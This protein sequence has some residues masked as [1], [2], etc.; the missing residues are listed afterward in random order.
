MRR[1]LAD[2]G[3]PAEYGDGHYNVR[4]ENVA[5]PLMWVYPLEYEC[6]LEKN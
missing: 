4:V 3:E 1:A 6:P 5:S 2:Q